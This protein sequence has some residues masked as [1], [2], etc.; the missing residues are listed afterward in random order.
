MS[1]P[2]QPVKFVPGPKDASFSLLSDLP[3]DLWEQVCSHVI[4]SYSHEFGVVDA[5]PSRVGHMTFNT[6]AFCNHGVFVSGSVLLPATGK[7]HKEIVRISDSFDCVF[8]LNDMFPASHEE[9]ALTSPV[10]VRAEL[11]W[12]RLLELNRTARRVSMG[13]FV[14][15]SNNVYRL[16]D[17]VFGG[18][19]VQYTVGSYEELTKLM[20][21]KWACNLVNIPDAWYAW[22]PR[23]IRTK[24]GV[25]SRSINVESVIVVWLK[26]PV[27]SLPCKDE[28][29]FEM[30]EQ[31][32][33]NNVMI[34][35]PMVWWK[36]L[37]RAREVRGKITAT[38]SHIEDSGSTRDRRIRFV[39]NP[40]T[41]P[42]D[43]L[44]GIKGPF[45]YY[46]CK[47]GV[48]DAVGPL[49]MVHFESLIA[50][51]VYRYWFNE[52]PGDGITVLETLMKVLDRGRI[53]KYLPTATD[54]QK[55]AIF[56]LLG[57][58]KSLECLPVAD[59]K[60]K[61]QLTKKSKQLSKLSF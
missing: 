22:P 59:K 7:P 60:T 37:R 39:K 44:C 9:N 21:K 14:D 30:V 38:L 26:L 61:L 36:G 42:T 18:P 29:K 32:E 47:D 11:F 50:C 54:T 17:S 46:T 6:P 56:K 58:G 31:H 8:N 3:P 51:V 45:G 25:L 20:V 12:R 27:V 53:N 33:T 19:D 5:E 35:V 1:H 52:C 49:E 24:V 23:R 2:R 41:Q 28:S 48:P 15:E 34:T 43:Q 4:P 55:A 10:D 40:A 16:S 57:P 13:L